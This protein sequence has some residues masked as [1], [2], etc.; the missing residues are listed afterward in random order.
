MATCRHNLSGQL[1]EFSTRRADTAT[2]TPSAA[3]ALAMPRPMPTLAPVTKAVLFL[4]CKS[5]GI[6][7]KE[8]DDW[9][10]A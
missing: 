6:F 2:R 4:S 8:I 3:R 7:E 1:M 5:M 9:T 10:L